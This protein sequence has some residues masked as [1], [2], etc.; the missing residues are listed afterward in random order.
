MLGE[1]KKTNASVNDKHED[2]P[3]RLIRSEYSGYRTNIS[4]RKPDPDPAFSSCIAVPW[5]LHSGCLT[6]SDKIC[7]MEIHSVVAQ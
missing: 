1:L 2:S 5:S 4:S 3:E 6:A 7:C